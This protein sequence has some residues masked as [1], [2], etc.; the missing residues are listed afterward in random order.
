MKALGFPSLLVSLLFYLIACTPPNQQAAESPTAPTIASESTRAYIGNASGEDSVGIYCMEVNLATGELSLLH[1]YPDIRNP[2]YLAIDPSGAYLYAA[3]AVP[4]QKE[5]GVSAFAIDPS[6]GRLSLLNQQ[7]TMGRGA[8]YVSVNPSSTYAF[9]ANYGSGSVAAFP[10]GKQGELGE[11]SSVV[12]HEGSGPNSERQE[13]PHAHYIQSGI[14]GFLYAADLG[15]DKVNLYKLAP[16]TGELQTGKPAY[17]TVDPGRGPRH[18]DFHPS[19]RFVYIMNEL[20]GSVTGYS[21]SEA[22]GSFQ[23]IQTI[24]SLP[25]DF[26]GYNK[27][28][29][30]H[31]HPNGRF[32]Y[33]SNRGDL[34]S[35]AVYTIDTETGRLSLADIQSEGIAWP[36]NFAI[37]P[38]GAFLLVANRDTD[39]I[40]SFR[41]DPETGLLNDTGFTVSVPKPICVKFV[42]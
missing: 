22:E 23:T 16:T 37:D 42:P 27:S 3:H 19:G 6:S 13:G 34:N 41:I 4:N 18:L 20:I 21:Y 9:A 7:S 10:I 36:R 12:Q 14:G 28:A 29:D 8:C 2:G 15:T 11:A 40:R 25:E 39:D 1:Q 38:T 35:I 33:A 24:S 30:I 32:L 31:V 17:L 5:G 26:D